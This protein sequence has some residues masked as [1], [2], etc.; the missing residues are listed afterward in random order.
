MKYVKAVAATAVAVMLLT[1]VAAQPAAASQP[2]FEPE[3]GTFPVSFTG[4]GGALLLETQSAGGV[5]RTVSC[6]GNSNTGKINS[7]TTM[8]D[9]TFKFTGCGASGPFGIG[10]TCTSS[11]AKSGEIVTV[12]LEG[13]FYYLK[14]N[15]SEAGV[16]FFVKGGGTIASFA[17]G[18]SPPFGESFTVSKGV[19]GKLTPVN[20]NTNA[21]SLTF[22]QTSGHQE[23][24]S[25]LSPTG[26]ASTSDNL[27]MSGTGA[28]TFSGIGTGLSA[29]VSL[30]TATKGKVAS[31]QCS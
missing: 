26:C 24:S 9:V 23:P 15:S 8:T 10:L 6:T 22:A 4:V 31:T 2:K 19:I 18:G 16:D 13:T 11:G 28:E 3:G 7:A 5:V 20:S 29:A 17:C 1:G 21:F 30:T 14:A 27:L 25:Y 12:G